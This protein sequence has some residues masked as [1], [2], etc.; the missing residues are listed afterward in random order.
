MPKL[1]L[2]KLLILQHYIEKY[3]KMNK[4][5]AITDDIDN[6]NNN[7][8]KITYTN[9]I[10]SELNNYFIY[11][12]NITLHEESQI[13]YTDD[14]KSIRSIYIVGVPEN[15]SPIVNI[16]YCKVSE[17]KRM[18]I[19]SNLKLTE[20]QIETFQETYK[21][22]NNFLPIYN[23]DKNGVI[24]DIW[25]NN[26]LNN[27]NFYLAINPFNGGMDFI[28]NSLSKIYE[29]KY[30][31]KRYELTNIIFNPTNNMIYS[32]VPPKEMITTIIV[33]PLNFYRTSFKTGYFLFDNLII[34]IFSKYLLLGG[35]LIN[36]SLTEQY[37][38]VSNIEN[39]PDIVLNHLIKFIQKLGFIFYKYNSEQNYFIGYNNDD[40]LIAVV[41]QYNKF[42]LLFDLKENNL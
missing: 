23:I 11:P 28:P 17:T 7:N 37:N 35:S 12:C 42:N 21:K 39:I 20:S 18:F 36:E 1:K 2:Y 33:M 4:Q 32:L 30:I 5:I 13:I 31:E 26:I 24:Y 41:G 16:A 6:I 34:R 27:Q 14:A 19:Y 38:K 22:D 10:N 8:S 3:I 9:P 40:N 25:N 15:I 29:Y